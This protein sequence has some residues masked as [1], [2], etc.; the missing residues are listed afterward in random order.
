MNEI[1]IND[2]KFTKNDY[3]LYKGF[4]NSNKTYIESLPSKKQLNLKLFSFSINFHKKLYKD[5]TFK[6]I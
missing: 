1:E 5:I 3:E 2:N 6:E 4:L